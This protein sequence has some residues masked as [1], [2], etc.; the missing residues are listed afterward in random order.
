M[1]QYIKS[2]Q[3]KWG[4]KFWFRCLSKSGYLY[5]MDIYLRRKQKP[6]FNIGLEEEVVLKLT[7]DL[8]RSFCTVYFDNF[9]NSPK[10]IEKLSQKSVYGIGPVR[11]NRKQMS[12]MIDDKQMKRGD[13]KFL[14]SGNTMAC[15]WMDNWSVLLLSSALEGMNDILLVQRR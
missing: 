11:A 9:F 4:F 8:K 6:E 10:L 2:K 14:F 15:K 3:I 1:K 5:Q 7:K 13:C 12:K